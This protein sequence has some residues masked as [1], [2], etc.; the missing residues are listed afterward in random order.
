MIP[1]PFTSETRLQLIQ[2][3]IKKTN[4][5]SYLEI[6]CDKDKIWKRIDCE[7]KIGVD[8]VRGGNC[9]MTSDDFFIQNNQKFDVVFIDGL[10]YYD[11]VSKDFNNSLKFLNDNG[12]IILHDMLPLTP[13]EAVTPIPEP[14]PRS[15]LGDVWRLAFD[16]MSRSD[17]TFKLVL[18]DNGCGI[19]FKTPQPPKKLDIENNWNFY[20]ENW[21]E[22]PLVSYNK[23]LNDLN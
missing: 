2:L 6:G 15:W 17:I 10:H 4:A 11:Q 8:P 22:L 21:Q 23:I 3:A 7:N 5:K 12:I 13:E 14:L 20:K 9:R 18:I 19:V 16:L 1:I